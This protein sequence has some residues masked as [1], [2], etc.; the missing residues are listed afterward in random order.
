M[1]NKNV[2]LQSIS[3]EDQYVLHS[4]YNFGDLTPDIYS[5]YN[6]FIPPRKLTELLSVAGQGYISKK[7]SNYYREWFVSLA[8]QEQKD[9]CLYY[10]VLN[11]THQM[12]DKKELLSQ[13][14]I[15]EYFEEKGVND[16]DTELKIITLEPALEKILSEQI[17]EEDIK[18][19]NLS[20]IESDFGICE[21]RESIIQHDHKLLIYGTEDSLYERVCILYKLST[22]DNLIW[23]EQIHFLIEEFKKV[24]IDVNTVF[25]NFEKYILCQRKL[26]KEMELMILNDLRVPQK[27]VDELKDKLDNVLDSLVNYFGTEMISKNILEEEL[28]IK[29]SKV[30]KYTKK[31]IKKAIKL[32]K[33]LFNNNNIELFISGS[34][35]E[36]TGERFNYFVKKNNTSLLYHTSN[37]ISVH[38][39]YRLQ[40]L[41][42]DSVFLCEACIVFEETPIIDQIIAL[43][44]H[45]Q[46]GNE[47]GFLEKANFFNKT[48]EFYN[49]E[50]FQ[51]KF[52]V[53]DFL[54][55]ENAEE[56]SYNHIR[57]QEIRDKVEAKI[58]TYLYDF[59]GLKSLPKCIKENQLT[60]FD[61]LYDE[62]VKNNELYKGKLIP[63]VEV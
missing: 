48:P 35:F 13:N 36:I 38:I 12:M 25:V 28:S 5:A 31:S 39:P 43:T 45:I 21:I 55:N 22:K 11:L 41:N 50:Y 16:K 40:I 10:G 2:K 17:K 42:K 30:E 51:G 15:E 33:N 6:Y 37:P 9:F 49:E 58:E 23:L 1:I 14:M 26:K 62:Y 61:E 32:F 47:E 57:Y 46:S 44:L 34:G 20:D 53:S 63:Y 54:N 7:L 19:I 56:K 4:M 8:T 52:K 24:K 18:V 59:I 60:W 3:P 27:E 29:K